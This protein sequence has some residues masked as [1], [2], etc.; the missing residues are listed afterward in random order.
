MI[1]LVFRYDA[2]DPEEFEKAYGSNG[3]W[4]Q[5]FSG[6]VRGDDDSAIPGGGRIGRNERR[7]RAL[8]RLEVHRSNQPG[9][10]RGYHVNAT[11]QLAFAIVA[12]RR[13]RDR[14]A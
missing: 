5:F 14:A 4:A 2:R 1:A 12:I 9:G 11:C 13:P 7:D 6:A 3:E 8:E 10:A